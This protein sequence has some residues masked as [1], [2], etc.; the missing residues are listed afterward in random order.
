MF[1]KN[2]FQNVAE[3]LKLGRFVLERFTA[4]ADVEK[5]TPPE[6]LRMA[7]EQLGPTFVKFGQLLA[8]R[9]D[10]VPED[11]VEEF[12]KLHDQVQAV[13]FA[14]LQKVLER[15]FGADISTVF[16]EIDPNPLAAA[17][18]AQVHRAVLIDGTSV[19]VKIQRPGIA[20]IIRDDVDIL[21]FLAELL[22]S[23]VPESRVYNPQ[24]MVDEFFRTL[25]LETNFIV[26]ANNIRRF[27]ENFKT[28]QTIKIP[29]VYFEYSGREVLVLEALQGVPLSHKGALTQ[30]GVNPKALM[31]AG[32]RAYF[33][34]V[35]KDGIFHGDLHA[36]NL[37]ILPDNRL[38]LI[39]FGIV[40]RLNRR[41]Q[42]SIANMF[43][44]LYSEDYERLAYEYVDLAPYNDQ[45]DIDEFARDLQG[46]LAPYFGLSMKNVN[47]GLLLMRT[48]GVAA[49]HRLMLPAELMLFFKSIVTVEGMGRIIAKDFDLLSY[50]L[51][52]ASELVKLKY[53]PKR[54]RDDF[55]N[56][57]RDS[58]DL[59]YEL[60]RQVKH[61]VRKLNHPDFAVRFSVNEMEDLKRSIETSSNIIFLGFVI[62]ALILSGSLTLFLQRGP[63]LFSLPAISTLSYSLAAILG[64]VA[65][66]NYIRK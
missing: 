11:V 65:F 29:H 50:A 7:F 51:E 40:G 54:I 39:D 17:S 30:E 28:D 43:V 15:Q 48:T 31:T 49:K 26:E 5:F 58:A 24:A 14:H 61:L 6:R 53:E 44:A 38:G 57:A 21:Y 45:V 32:I 22:N 60:P 66:R 62:G 42:D 8:T 25:E 47:L 2:G 41:T 33:K 63:Y 46:L 52:F 9:P 3:R 12:K 20:A 37:F 59:L 1:A 16:R 23:Y 10:L 36:G 18:I 13:P 19:V 34:M 4:S 35:F 55:I 64:L 27:T 56:V